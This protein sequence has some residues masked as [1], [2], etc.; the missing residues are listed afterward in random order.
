MD[1]RLQPLILSF[2]VGVLIMAGCAG[3]SRD[4]LKRTHVRQLFTEGLAY[5]GLSEFTSALDRYENVIETSS[6]SPWR[7]RAHL[8]TARIY[9][10]NL[11]QPDQSIRHYRAFLD[12][13]DGETLTEEVRLELARLYRNEDRYG[14]AAEQYEIVHDTASSAENREE[15]YYYLGEVY[16]ELE[17]Y[18]QSISV[19]ESFLKE[20]PEGD[21]ADGALLNLA[22]NYRDL[23]QYEAEMNAYR[24]LLEEYPESGLR[25]YTY[26]QALQSAVKQGDRSRAREWARGYREEFGQGQYWTEMSNRLDKKFNINANVLDPDPLI[27]D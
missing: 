1:S 15:A 11:N 27:T 7:R 23:G 22:R 8:R 4:S 5:E 21:L 26:F 12:E 24:R 9:Q 13:A 25:E 14:E 16:R 2:L 19:Y 17:R 18:Q 6:A 3:V 20:F 10:N